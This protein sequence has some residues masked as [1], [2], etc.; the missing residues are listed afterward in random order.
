VL[1]LPSPAQS[2]KLPWGYTGLRRACARKWP[3][4]AG[5]DPWSVPSKSA[6]SGCSLFDPAA[7]P[8]AGAAISLS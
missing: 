4:A 3:T 1:Q 5:A 8:V 2:A 6:A 7:A